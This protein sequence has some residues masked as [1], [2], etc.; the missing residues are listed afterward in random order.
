LLTARKELTRAIVGLQQVHLRQTGL[1]FRVATLIQKWN[2]YQG[3]WNRTNRDIEAG[4][5]TRHVATA[6]RHAEAAG[7]SFPAEA[8]GLHTGHA[9]AKA[10]EL[11]ESQES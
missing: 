8:M 11:P 3:Y 5:Y 1:R 9:G 7:L 4:R 6:R 2:I 10:H